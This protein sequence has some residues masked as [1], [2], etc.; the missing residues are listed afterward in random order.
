M[1]ER[2]IAIFEDE[3]FRKIMNHVTPRFNEVSR[4]SFS[5]VLR[6]AEKKLDEKFFQELSKVKVLGA[7]TDV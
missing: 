2:P 5:R 7:T 4:K 1:S 3:G 6:Q